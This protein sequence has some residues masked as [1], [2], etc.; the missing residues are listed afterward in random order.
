M[1][2]ILRARTTPP[3]RRRSGKKLAAAVVA[4]ATAAATGI[5]VLS[6]GCE[7]KVAC[8][9]GP[10]RTQV[11]GLHSCR[12]DFTT[13]KG[14]YRRQHLDIDSAVDNVFTSDISRTKNHRMPNESLKQKFPHRTQKRNFTIRKLHLLHS[15]PK[16]LWLINQD[17]KSH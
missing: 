7:A 4:A 13:S 2:F 17:N 14:C 5:L 12:S 6:P 3:T 11:T 10:S 1:E 15:A 16:I 9:Q 8:V